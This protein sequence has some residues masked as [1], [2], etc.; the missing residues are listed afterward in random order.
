MGKAKIKEVKLL[1]PKLMSRSAASH[2]I[3]LYRTMEAKEQER[4][5]HYLAQQELDKEVKEIKAELEHMRGMYEL[6]Y[7]EI[8][9]K[10]PIVGG[11]APAIVESNG[12][13][14]I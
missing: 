14:H 8:E 10:A 7:E 4:Y 5:Q 12:T 1:Y 11:E 13:I 3:R 6:V 2:I 9:E